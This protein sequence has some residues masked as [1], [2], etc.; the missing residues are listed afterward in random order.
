MTV[1][2]PGSVFKSTVTH[3]VHPSLMFFCVCVFP[4]G[5]KHKWT[6]AALSHLPVAP[7]KMF[8]AIRKWK[9]PAREWKIIK[10]DS[11]FD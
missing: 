6:P 11:T 3:P 2:L 10:T 9:Q 5:E 7:V 4:L 8:T 1:K